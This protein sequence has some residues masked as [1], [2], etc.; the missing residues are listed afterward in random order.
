MFVSD[1]GSLARYVIA[2]PLFVV[3]ESLCF[4][5]FEQII[6]HFRNSGLIE[7]SD[8]ERYA[9]IVQSSLRLLKSKA[10]EVVSFVVAYAIVFAWYLRRPP[11][12]LIRWSYKAGDGLTLAGTWHALITLPLLL[13]LLLGWMWRQ[14]AWGRFLWMVSRMNLRL[15]ASHPDQCGGLNFVSTVVRAYRPIAFACSSIVAGGMSNRIIHGGS[16]VQAYPEVMIGVVLLI[17]LFC[18]APLLVFARTLWN[19]QVKAIFEYGAL[20]RSIGS[21]LEA[22]WLSYRQ[23]VPA[24][25]LEVQDFSATTDLYSVTANTY[26]LYRVPFAF[27]TIRDLLI[28]TVLPFIPVLLLAV[29]IKT[30]LDTILKVALS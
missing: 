19:L 3:A 5:R 14:F 6:L 29:P 2:A 24:D 16:R 7:D 25:A 17:I 26:K 22:K 10:A 13:V 23:R 11:N 8:R 20:A 12:E 1:F 28:F 27:G 9:Q 15:L 18:M 4:S 21:Q 30:I